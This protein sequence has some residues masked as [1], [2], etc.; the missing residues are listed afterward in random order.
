[1][2]GMV[3]V[4]AHPWGEG[5]QPWQYVAALAY[6]VH[7]VRATRRTG[8]TTVFNYQDLVGKRATSWAPAS[9][10]PVQ[11]LFG[12]DFSTLEK[13]KETLKPYAKYWNTH[14]LKQ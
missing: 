12:G 5:I 2:P 3:D 14:Y 10:R 7:H 11:A 8:G 4:H 13:T 9:S 6:G 1:M